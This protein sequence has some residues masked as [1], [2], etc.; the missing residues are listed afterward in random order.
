MQHVARKRF[1]QNFLKDNSVIEKI[2]LNI[3]INKNDFFLEIGPGLG[4]L[5]KPLMSKLGEKSKLY[6]VEIDKDLA[7]YLSKIYEKEPRFVIASRDILKTDI[8]D[9]FE[10]DPMK[11]LRVVGNLPY[12]IS[13]QLIFHLLSNKFRKKSGDLLIEDMHFMLQKEVVD[14]MTASPGCKNYGRLSIMVQ[15]H[16]EVEDLLLVPST[17][18]TPEPKVTSKIIR[19]KPFLNKDLNQNEEKILAMLVKKCFEQRRKTLKNSL[20]N[21]FSEREFEAI[22]INPSSRPEL[23]SINDFKKLVKI[24]R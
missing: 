7:A 11:T 14:R 10:T 5:T 24:F 22:E 12:N 6:A 13:T 15:Y 9:I 1:S 19:L 20:K 18:F 3:N 23:L 21:F 16:C 2:L 17:A 4:A 8:E